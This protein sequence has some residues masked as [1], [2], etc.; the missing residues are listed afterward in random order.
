MNL[1]IKVAKGEY[2]GIVET[3][4]FIDKNMYEELYELA[5]KKDVD[6]IKENYTMFLTRESGVLLFSSDICKDKTLYEKQ[7]INEQK[8][9]LLNSQVVIWSSLYKRSFITDNNILFNETLGASYQDNGFW[10]ITSVLASNVF[11]HNN[12]HYYLR[13]DNPTS[14]VS[15]KGNVYSICSEYN[16]IYD[17]LKANSQR[18]NNYINFYWKALY[19]NYLFTLKRIDYKYKKEFINVFSK[20]LKEGFS[21]EEIELSLFDQQEKTTLIKIA[22]RPYKVDLKKQKLRP[23]N[24]KEETY[25]QRLLYCYEDNG[26]IYTIKHIF[27]RVIKIIIN[28]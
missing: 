9:V 14:S 12:S 23:I 26:L 15:S 13:R 7:L 19:N 24:I 3:D 25:F 28:H 5:T 11:F 16:Y 18:Y 27:D 1:G 22:Y 17:F 20:E 6:F 10:F 2:I 8:R 4:D 21:R